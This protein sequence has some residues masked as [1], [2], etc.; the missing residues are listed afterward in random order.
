MW[1]VPAPH[2][3]PPTWVVVEE[4]MVL[5]SSTRPSCPLTTPGPAPTLVLSWAGAHGPQKEWGGAACFWLQWDTVVF[6]RSV[7]TPLFPTM[8][9]RRACG[10]PGLQ[11]GLGGLDLAKWVKAEAGQS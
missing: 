3:S 2:C 10:N 1:Q 4:D 11:L 8:C 5:G 6:S 7:G 9:R